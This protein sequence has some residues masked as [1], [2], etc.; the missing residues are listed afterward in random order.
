MTGSRGGRRLAGECGLFKR[1]RARGRSGRVRGVVVA[2]AACLGIAFPVHSVEGQAPDEDWRTIHTEHFRVTFPLR[3]EPLARRAAD[4]SERAWKELSA[5]FVEP[6]DDVIDVVVT[7]HTDVSNGFAQVTPSNR[8][9]IFARP[10]IDALSLGHL[11]EWLELVITHELAHI[12]HLDLV[13]NPI[14]RGLRAVFGRVS[15]EWPFFPELGTPR[16]VTEGLATWYES[17]LTGAG[18][19]RGTFEEMEIRTA[20][21]EDR[22]ENIG[23]ASGD[24]PLWPGGNRPYAYGSIFFDFLM[25]RHGEDQMAAFAEA[26]AGQWVPYRLNSAGRGAFGVS[27]SEEWTAWEAELREE[28]AD[29]DVRLRQAGPVTDPERLTT[30]AR[31]ALHP[32]VSPDGRWLVHTRSDGRSD[33][34]L[35]IRDRVTGDERS[36]GRTNGLVTYSWTPDRQLVVSQLEFEDPYRTWA[37]L[38]LFDLEGGQTRLTRSARTSQP[39]VAPDGTYAVA[40]QDGDGTNALVR[41]DLTTGSIVP[42]VPPS[43]DVHWA[44]P[45][46]SP[47]GRWIAVTRWEPDANHDL[48]ILDAE[49]GRLAHEVTS[50]RALDLAGAWSPDGRWLVWASDRTGIPNVLGA[51]VDSASGRPSEPQLLTNVRTGAAYPSIDPSGAWLYF[52][53]YHADGWDVERVPFRPEEGPV[54][55]PAVRRFVAEGEPVRRGES[56]APMEEYSPGPTLRP[57][58]WEVTYREAVFTPS[59]TGPVQLPSREVLGFSLGAQTGGRDL[60]GRHAYSVFGRMTTAGRK[61]DGGLSYGFFGLASPLLSVSATQAHRDG[62]QTTRGPDADPDA[63]TLVFVER[64][65]SLEGAITI[66]VPRWRRNLRFTLSG[67]FT[68]EHVEVWEEDL[69]PS[70]S[71]SVTRP[72]RRLVDAGASVNFNTSRSHSFQMGTARGLNVFLQ[73]RLQREVDAPPQDTSPG[74][75]RSLVEMLGRVTGALP[76]WGGGHATHVLAIQASGGVAQGAGAGS[77]HYRVGGASGQQEALTGTTLFGGNFIFFPVR[78]YDGSSRFGRYAWTASAEYRFPLWLI[79]RGLGAWP[80]H[81]DRAIGS[82]FVDAGNAWGPD[83]SPS[84][85]ENGR[86]SA[87]AS[88]G[89]ELTTQVLGLYDVELRLR[90]GF[91][92]P[93]VPL[94]PGLSADSPRFYLR[95]GLP[96]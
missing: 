20:V 90:F 1:G 18:R 71:Y 12:M 66:P 63:D 94:A 64:A 83:I 25:E 95:V 92:V 8:I 48:V 28:L 27:L 16:W 54:A 74:S 23:Q 2:L 7:D 53:G 38:Y 82:V 57:T 88:A 60:V 75:D 33:L 55:G 31:W 76:L 4:R 22:F 58:F 61:F 81:L 46:L 47:D 69:R 35:R 84:G 40:V 85:A 39:T 10:P 37:D 14:G 45:R 62:G 91:A 11:D 44:F 29:L 72:S 5:L 52:S 15:A 87:L 68:W 93:L 79:N 49:S 34:Q 51:R 6:P 67:G 41:V 17:R 73:G 89:F 30:G 19:V 56:E 32:T 59:V 21:L 26:I 96:Y 3:L 86:R 42:L 80:L 78:G 9:T 43:P 77:L 50:D 65:R 36:L 24:S 13:R 70:R